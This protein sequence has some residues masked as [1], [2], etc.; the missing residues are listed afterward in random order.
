MFIHI[1]G[2]KTVHADDIV[3]I[4]NLNAENA[5]QHEQWLAHE[6]RAGRVRM[7]EGD[8]HKC[9]VIVAPRGRKR[10]RGAQ[11]FLSPVNP[12]TIVKRS[13]GK[14]WLESADEL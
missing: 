10:P 3:M 1:G 4:L 2:E 14:P 13:K 6:R 9:A 11:I 8:V 12:A 5:V 7:L